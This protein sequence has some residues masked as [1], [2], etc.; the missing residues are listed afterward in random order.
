VV[1]GCSAPSWKE[2]PLAQCWSQC[3]SQC[4]VLSRCP[5]PVAAGSSLQL[6]PPPPPPHH[7]LSRA[8]PAHG[9]RPL[10]CPG[11]TSSSPLRLACAR[12]FPSCHGSSL[13]PPTHRPPL[14]GALSHLASP[15]PGDLE[16]GEATWKPEG[17]RAS[18][19]LVTS[20]KVPALRTV[21]SSQKQ[22]QDN[23][24]WEIR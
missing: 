9:W 4:W 19:Q 14:L 2:E 11:L 13:T 21:S 17:T 15:H 6:H 20:T 12:A 18:Y 23:R 1:P 22:G 8:T 16:P 3:W 10:H 5:V 24:L 7:R